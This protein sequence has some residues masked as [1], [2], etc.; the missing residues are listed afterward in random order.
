M[1]T[2]L[3]LA[4]L[5]SQTTAAEPHPF[6][7]GEQ[8]LYESLFSAVEKGEPNLEAPLQRLI[9]AAPDNPRVHRLAG[10]YYRAVHDSARAQAAFERALGLGIGPATRHAETLVALAD[11]VWATD[12]TTARSYLERALAETP[13]NP[14]VVAVAA[15]L[16]ANDGRTH[17]A[18]EHLEHLAALLP[19]DGKLRADL[20]AAQWND[21]S[22]L[23]AAESVRRARELG[24]ERDYFAQIESETRFQRW[25]VLAGK[26][27]GISALVLTTILGTIALAG[28]LLSRA[29]IQ[30]LADVH[31]HLEAHE[32]TR[33][34]ARVDRVYSVVLWVAASLLFVALPVLVVGTLGLGVGLIWAMLSMQI[35]FLKPV[36][37]VAVGTL[38]AVFGLFR[39]LFFRRPLGE[40]KFIARAEEPRL[41]GLLDE[42]AIAAR[43]K[44]VDQVILQPG[45]GVGVR[46]DGSTL[47]VLSG[48]GKRVLA[49]GYGALQQ[50]TVGELSAVLAHEYGHF[51]HG[52][53]RLTPI[54]WRVEVS[55]VR[56]LM[57]MGA[58]GRMVMLNPAFWFLRWYMHVYVRITRGQGRRRELLAD[59]LAALTY[60]GDTF[61]RALVSASEADEDL[62]R[63]LNLLGTLRSVGLDGEPLY[64]L[65][66]M[67]RQQTAA[68]LRAA[69]AADRSRRNPNPFDTH[70]PIADRIRRVVG[71]PGARADDP[72]PASSL[73]SNP[74]K[75]AS[76][77]AAPLL[78]RLPE[79]DPDAPRPLKP[80]EVSRAVS[81]LQDAYG[82]KQH[83][84]P[85]A[86]SAFEESLNE[87][88]NTLGAQHPFLAEHFRELSESRRRAG[89]TAG[90]EAAEQ[91]ATAIEELVAKRRED[92]HE[93][94]V[95]HA[96]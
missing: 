30:S 72:R 11:V 66:D 20:A 83:G 61:A 95:Q 19:A 4:L 92:A 50:L 68:P 43:A 47:E 38:L 10:Y 9:S 84:L 1:L 33:G 67:K 3:L 63:A 31:A 90:A 85:G 13:D 40:G 64:H 46:E 69:L 94:D 26:I 37:V 6:P 52:E 32:R 65:Q 88:S 8:A 58:G 51:S 45:P 24:T 44:P 59:R 96:P 18:R 71:M 70:P 80:A 55:A 86:L 77:V 60:G 21:G 15:R 75:S 53:T 54:L 91:R 56:M 78:A 5:S 28:L 12:R 79:P 62:L 34:E 27:F 35:V 14:H 73:L 41:Y 76:E 48:R 23:A 16:D 57:G 22:H 25:S 87:L 93:A 42:V 49:L 82:L 39:G 81:A 7:P 36:L 89:D 2:V 17:E 74:E 29:E